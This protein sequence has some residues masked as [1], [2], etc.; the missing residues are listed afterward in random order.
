MKRKLILI[1][2]A[3]LLS[4]L[5]IAQP[6]EYYLWK[7]KSTSKTMCNPDAPDANWVKVSGPYEHSNCSILQPK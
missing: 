4:G 3:T 5:A 7:H 1:L 2:A 6:S